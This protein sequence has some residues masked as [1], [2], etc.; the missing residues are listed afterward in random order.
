[1]ARKPRERMTEAQYLDR[2]YG[3]N[4]TREE[5]RFALRIFT[6]AGYTLSQARTVLQSL[7]HSNIIL[8]CDLYQLCNTAV[9]ANKVL[10]EVSRKR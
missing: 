10:K 8:E 6:G 3:A 4:Y 7:I 1:M 2:I 5:K 9:Y